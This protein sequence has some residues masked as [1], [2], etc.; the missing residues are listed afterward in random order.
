[1]PEYLSPGVYVEEFEIGAKPIEGVSTSTAGFVGM[2]EMGPLDKPTLVTNFGEYQR[3]FGGYLD[4]KDYGNKCYLPYSVEGFFSNGGQRLYVT[5][6]AKR[7]QTDEKD[8]KENIALPSKGFLPDVSGVDTTLE[9]DVNAISRTIKVKTVNGLQPNDTLLLKDGP[10]SEYLK[11]VG[12]VIDLSLRSSLKNSYD[13]TGIIKKMVDDPATNIFKIK[14]VDGT[15]PMKIVLEAGETATASTFDNDFALLQSGDVLFS[16]SNKHIYIIVGDPVVSEKSIIVDSS[17]GL[18][19]GLKFNKIVES[20]SSSDQTTI[21]LPVKNGDTDLI[22]ADPNPAFVALTP[23]MIGTGTKNE[24]HL[25]DTVD[26]SASTDPKII[27]VAEDLKYQHKYLD[28]NKAKKEIKQ[29]IKAVGVEAANEGTWGNKIKISVID[30]PTD[31]IKL[32]KEAVNQNFLELETVTGI[33]EGTLLK[34]HVQT[35]IYATVTEVLRTEDTA[36]VDLDVTISCPLTTDI[37][38]SAA[39]FDI[40][41]SFDGSEEVFKNLSLNSTHS[42]YIK[43]MV[44][45]ETSNFIRINDV[46]DKK[47]PLPTKDKLP[48]WKLEEGND[49]IPE[50]SELSIIY[51]GEDNPEPLSRTGLQ[52]LK[53]IDDISIVAMPGISVQDLQNQLIIHCETLK[54]RFAVLDSEA[55]AELD[56]IQK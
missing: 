37:E 27:L 17:T 24:Y 54:D 34:I 5:R 40:V 6:V 12:S 46:V 14:T 35:P 18:T 39:E 9:A 53:N 50:D 29:L 19:P 36:R 41:V 48:G 2:T 51:K 42:R 26:P 33:E 38:V 45:A 49:G 16:D 31:K 44:T 23:I 25:I 47:I 32:K 56:D 10:Q 21:L 30:S 4:Q 55:L 7:K 28:Q 8:K 43:K 1:M 52:T 20:G 13:T 3:I 11:Y 15:N 22:I